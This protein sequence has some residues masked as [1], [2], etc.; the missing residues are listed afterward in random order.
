MKEWLA[1][2]QCRGLSFVGFSYAILERHTGPVRCLS[3]CSKVRRSARSGC[4]TCWK[5]NHLGLLTLLNKTVI[6]YTEANSHGQFSSD[7]VVDIGS[8][9]FFVTATPMTWVSVSARK[10][11]PTF[12]SAVTNFS[13]V[14]VRASVSS[15]SYR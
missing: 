14:R 6:A 13:S 2:L 4:T 1:P 10:T 8:S 5:I 15:A 3:I 11:T 7:L 9:A 12:S